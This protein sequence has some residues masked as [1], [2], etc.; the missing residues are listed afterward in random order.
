[1]SEFSAKTRLT[2][3]FMTKA[4]N[5]TFMGLLLRNI[6]P[7]CSG[8]IGKTDTCHIEI[9]IAPKVFTF[10]SG[11]EAE[12]GLWG[13]KNHVLPRVCVLSKFG[14]TDYH[15]L[16]IHS[17]WAHTLIATSPIVYLPPANLDMANCAEWEVIIKLFYVF[18]N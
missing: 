6:K 15:I 8:I 11:E 14:E 9:K 17:K 2:A 3:I 7:N 4:P 1:M 5:Y 18:A 13:N 12:A 10:P 16:V